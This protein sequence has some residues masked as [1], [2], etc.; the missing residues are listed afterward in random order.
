MKKMGRKSGA[1]GFAVYLDMIERLNGSDKSYDVD[2]VILY[3]DDAGLCEINE[4]VKL[5]CAN[6][7][8]VMVLREK[9]SRIKY[10]LLV[11]YMER[12][13]EIIEYNA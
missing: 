12:G 11:K 3:G 4:A 13:V 9:P 5:F 10:R 7:K 2:T 8:S 6:G 1:V